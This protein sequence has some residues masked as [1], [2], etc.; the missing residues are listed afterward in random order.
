VGNHY[1]LQLESR[2][3]AK[4]VHWIDVSYSVWFNRK[5]NRVGLLS[6][7]HFKAVLYEPTEALK[8]NRYI[9]FDPV[10]IAALGG[11]ETREVAAHEIVSNVWKEPW[12]NCYLLAAPVHARPLFSS[13]ESAVG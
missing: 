10:P 12:G 5:Y 13:A 11:H 2:T 4:A 7:G 6:Q 3:L 9:S 1:H 8:I